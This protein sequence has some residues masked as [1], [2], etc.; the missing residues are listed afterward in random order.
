LNGGLFLR[1]GLRDGHTVLLDCR[2]TY[3]LQVL[4]PHTEPAAG[5]GLSLVL[6]LLSG[7]LL[8]GDRVWM[9]VIVERGARLALRTQAATQL[10]AG[11]S[12]QRLQATVA[13]D[14]WFSYVPH[15][16]VPHRGA[17]YH[18]V[19][20][21]DVA[22]GSRA[23]IAD[24]LSPGRVQ[25]GESFAYDEVRL[26]LDVRRGATLLAHERASIRPE[27]AWREAQWG[28]FTHVASAYLLGPGEAPSLGESTGVRAGTT[29]LA[30]GGWLVRALANR[31]TALDDLLVGLSAR[32]QQFGVNLCNLHNGTRGSLV[33][34][35][36]SAREEG[37]LLSFGPY[38]GRP[39]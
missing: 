22:A 11:H 34:A 16:V 36:V 4:R 25:F 35:D 18:A 15:A 14:A 29:D 5:G 24:A 19:T 2:G 7:G 13:D 27:T 6:L 33:S 28:S 10:H 26:D 37:H 9:E 39:G 1:A 20:Q 38:G 17:D 3:P 31:A 8:D 23:L 12:E 32:W 30:G 21:V